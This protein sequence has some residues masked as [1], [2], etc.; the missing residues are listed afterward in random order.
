MQ[1]DT[2]PDLDEIWRLVSKLSAWL[3][4]YPGFGDG[5]EPDPEWSDRDS[6]ECGNALPWLLRVARERDELGDELRRTRNNVGELE[7]VSAQWMQATRSERARAEK[8]EARAKKL[9][10]A[11]RNFYAM[12]Q[13]E[14][15]ALLEDD[16]NAETVACLL[17]QKE[18]KP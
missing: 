12:V 10:M 18:P 14:A 6:E 2:T 9:E 11:L 5:D 7:E 8:A 16:H 3:K 13:G 4:T 15:P 1:P 17:A